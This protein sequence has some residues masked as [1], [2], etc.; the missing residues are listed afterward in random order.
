MGKHEQ[1][2][3]HNVARTIMGQLGINP[4]TV[5]LEPALAQEL[6]EK[7]GASVCGLVT[8]WSNPTL[9]RIAACGLDW[10]SNVN[11]SLYDVHCAT[12]LSKKDSGIVLLRE[13]ATT[14]IIAAMTDIVRAAHEKG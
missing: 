3:I 13:I 1:E 10:V 4:S 2:Y 8:R 12:W 11:T 5:T 14:A 6:Y 9:G 7:F